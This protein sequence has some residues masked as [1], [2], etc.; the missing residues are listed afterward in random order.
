MAMKGRRYD[1]EYIEGHSIWL[2][3]RIPSATLTVPFQK[4]GSYRA[5]IQG[6]GPRTPAS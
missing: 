2:D 6:S 5:R 3:L 1:L 4:D